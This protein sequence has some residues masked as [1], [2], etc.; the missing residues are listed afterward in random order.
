MRCDVRWLTCRIVL[1]QIRL[2]RVELI[3]VRHG[4]KRRHILPLQDFDLPLAEN[5]VHK[6]HPFGGASEVVF[7]CAVFEGHKVVFGVVGGYSEV[8]FTVSMP[9]VSSL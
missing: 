2:L 3:L 7:D 8:L 1:V 4:R 9:I 5:F 6:R